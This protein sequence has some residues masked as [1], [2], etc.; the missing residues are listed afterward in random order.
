MKLRY[1]RTHDFNMFGGTQDLEVGVEKREMIL[2]VTIVLVLGCFFFV[3][4][5]LFYFLAIL[6]LFL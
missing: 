6:V 1:K 2:V 4:F 3:F 5:G